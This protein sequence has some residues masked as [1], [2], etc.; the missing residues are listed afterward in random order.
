M[1]ILWAIF[2]LLKL[3]NKQK[4]LHPLPAKR[5]KNISVF[6]SSSTK[7]KHSLK[8]G[9]AWKSCGNTCLQLMLPHHF[10][11]SQT[12]FLTTRQ[13]RQTFPTSLRLQGRIWSHF[14]N[15]HTKTFLKMIFF[16]FINAQAYIVFR[17]RKRGKS[18]GTL[19]VRA[20]LLESS[21]HYMF[22][23]FKDNKSQRMDKQHINR[24]PRQ[25]I[26]KL[27]FKFALIL[28]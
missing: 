7:K 24:K 4:V 17:K 3:I 19:N 13:K 6:L 10:V 25:I 14:S 2:S 5:K 16:N 9:R 21:C 11:F 22:C 27:K 8:P 20:G 12:C 26:T 28:G 18:R 23:V 1:Y 15:N